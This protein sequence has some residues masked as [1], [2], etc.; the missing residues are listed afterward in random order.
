MLTSGAR[1]AT[2]ERQRRNYP[3]STFNAAFELVM[4]PALF[5]LLGYL[6]DQKVGTGRLF[7]F[8][9]AGLV[10]VY[11]VWKLWY[12][13]NLRVDSIHAEILR[14]RPAETPGPRAAEILHAVLTA[15]KDAVPT[16]EES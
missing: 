5:A 3:D 14:P 6:L 7:T 15:E 1:P 8:V 12:N 10:A 16:V 4:T 2:D 13:Y 9:F 11:E